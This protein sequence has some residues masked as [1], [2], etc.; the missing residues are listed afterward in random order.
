MPALFAVEFLHR[1][2]DVYA[3]YFGEVTPASLTNN[4]SS[5]YALLEEMLDNGY[6]MISEPNA[7]T[8]LIA[9]PSLSGGMSALFTGKSAVSDTIGEGAMSVIPWR[10][11]GVS[12][13]ANEIFF[14]VVEEIDCIVESNGTLVAHDVR[15]AI[16]AACRMSGVPD[17]TLSFGDPKIIEDASF[18]PCVRY[19][20]YERD[21]VVS[22]VP[23]DGD[24]LLM[25]YRVVDRAAPSAPLFCRPQV[26]WREGSGRAVFTLGAKPLGKAATTVPG[27]VSS[28]RTGGL[29]NTPA[30]AAVGAAAA[31]AAAE[32]GAEDVKLVVTFPKAVKS[33]A[34]TSDVGTVSVDPKTGDV[35]WLV[36]RMPAGGKNP[37]LSGSLHLAPGA[38]APLE[39][40]SAVLSFSLAGR[41]VS[42][43]TVRDLVLVNEKYKFMKGVKFSV[44][45][46]RYSVRC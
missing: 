32:A 13:A 23:P 11:S 10:R 14:D 30:S 41:T 5:A 20:R 25:T 9:P 1:V 34:L 33:S 4:F 26:S 45:T 27:A 15:G 31:A 19:A 38:G 43:L 17:L 35:T 2:F 16:K 44:K 39:A 28:T 29:G 37:E 40:V 12:Y 3:G 8:T 18:H 24:F 36:G 46:G 21:G 42:G 6:P 7:L 22:F